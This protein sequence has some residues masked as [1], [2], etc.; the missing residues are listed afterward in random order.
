MAD[1]ASAKLLPT[2]LVSADEYCAER[3]VPKPAAK[4]AKE[5]TSGFRACIPAQGAGSIANII[6][7]G[8]E[9][10]IELTKSGSGL[11]GSDGE[12]EIL[13]NLIFKSLE[14]LEYEMKVAE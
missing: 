5:I 12:F 1:A 7:A 9:C 11:G 14:V 2:L 6:N 3:K 13:N 10:Y 8:W 4:A